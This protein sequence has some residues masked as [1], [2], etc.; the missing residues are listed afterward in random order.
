M[1]V[2]KVVVENRIFS[3][4]IVAIY[5]QGAYLSAWIMEFAVEGMRIKYVLDYLNKDVLL[6]CQNKSLQER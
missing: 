1:I 5:N 4:G 3:N 6:G 2:K